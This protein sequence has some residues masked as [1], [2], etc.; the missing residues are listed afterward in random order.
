MCRV[1]I[2]SRANVPGTWL[3][4]DSSALNFEDHQ[5]MSEAL[6]EVE[7]HQGKQSWVPS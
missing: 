1:R 3:V 5:V 4:F 7:G 6:W 2:Q